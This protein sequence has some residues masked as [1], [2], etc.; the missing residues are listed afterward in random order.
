MWLNITIH[1]QTKLFLVVRQLDFA[2]LRLI[3]QR[4]E[5]FNAVQCYA[6]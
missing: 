4:T 5:L 1:G 3:Q 6:R 2:S